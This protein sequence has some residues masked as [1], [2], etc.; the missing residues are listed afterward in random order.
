[1]TQRPE[2][3]V[4]YLNIARAAS[5]RSTCLR[6]RYGAIIVNNDEIISTGYNGTPR[7]QQNCSCV[8]Y[9]YRQ[10]NNIPAGERYELCKS[11][12]AEANACLSAARKD[13]IG[14]V[15]Y[16][17]GFDSETGEEMTSATPCKMCMRFILNSGITHVV[18]LIEGTL[19]W[20]P[21][22]DYIAELDNP[23]L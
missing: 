5:Q 19:T 6:R 1:M 7:L 17:A 13:M 9:C 8:G 18:S 21:V 20:T 14:G 12:H 11:V 16:L 2:K 22:T 3:D 4:Y 15:L 10:E 23:V